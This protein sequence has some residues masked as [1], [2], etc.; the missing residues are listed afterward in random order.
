MLFHFPLF[1]SGCFYIHKYSFDVIK[2]T[3]STPLNM[4]FDP[5]LNVKM[6]IM[7]GILTFMSRKNIILGLYD[8]QIKL[9]VL[10]FS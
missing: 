7:F 4:K 6:P 3:Y 8:P 2:N 1:Q 10:I 9:N 5:L